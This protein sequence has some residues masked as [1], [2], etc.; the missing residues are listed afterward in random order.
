[1]SAE[2]CAARR[3]ATAKARLILAEAGTNPTEFVDALNAVRRAEV[4]YAKA[5]NQ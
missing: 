1:M 5:V 2:E 3:L 4:E